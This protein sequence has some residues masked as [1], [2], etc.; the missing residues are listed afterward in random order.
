MAYFRKLP[1]GKWRAEVELAGTRKSQGGFRTKGEAAEWA[2]QQET[3]IRAG[4]AGKWPR[5]TLG[6]A[7]DR[8]L[9]EV[10]PHKGSAE[11]ERKRLEAL[12]RDYPALCAKQL[13]EVTPDDLGAWVAKRLKTVKPATVKRESNTFSNV[14]TVAARTW[15][16]CPLESPWTFTRVPSDGPPRT[17]R[18]SWREIKTICRRLGYRSG[19]PP[20]T[21]QQETAYAWLLALRTAMRSGELLGLTTESVNLQTRVARLDE[22]KTKRYT[23]RAR[24]VPFTKQAARLFGVLVQGKT[25]ALFRVSEGSRVALFRK[26]LSQIGIKGLRFHDSRAEALTLLSRKVDLLT[27]QKISGH[28][29]INVLQAHYY[30][31]TPEQVAA[32]L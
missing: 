29:D 1:S 11:W 32:R 10:T 3:D 13:T 9:L 28:V 31:E 26:A 30:R 7:L 12:K 14:W 20:I 27:L 17:R 24:F 5:K 8:Y 18:V 23:G 21:M 16:W 4:L 25:G 2:G 6:D 22:H 15:R 19:H